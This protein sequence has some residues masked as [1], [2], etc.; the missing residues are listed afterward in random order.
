MA[1]VNDE[2]REYTRDE[3]RARFLEHCR[4]VAKYWASPNLHSNPTIQDRTEGAIFSLLAT[5]DGSTLALPGF[6]LVPCP[7]P[8][9]KAYHQKE[10]ENWFPEPPADVELVDIGG[11]L[12]EHFFKPKP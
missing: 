9:D 4:S 2:P 1:R 6:M 7:H 12:H 8:E 5:L 10:G 3:I 11:A